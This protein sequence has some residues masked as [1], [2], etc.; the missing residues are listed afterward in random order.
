MNKAFDIAF[1][2]VI[3]NEGGYV[4]NPD[5]RGGETNFGISKKAYPHLDIKEITEAQAEKIYFADYWLKNQCNRI[6]N[7]SLAIKLFDMSVN[8]GVKQAALLLQRAAKATDNLPLLEDGIIGEKTLFAVN[9]LTNDI[10]N[11]VVFDRNNGLLCAFKAECA[12]FYRNLAS[13]D[14]SQ[15]RFLDGWLKRVFA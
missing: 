13:K 15:K 8:L 11:K 14:E 1:N 5:D 9:S 7:E 6:E 2:R 10:E 3:D 4:N 12:S